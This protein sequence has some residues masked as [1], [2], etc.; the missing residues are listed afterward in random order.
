MRACPVSA[1]DKGEGRRWGGA[2]LDRRSVWALV[3]GDGAAL[4]EEKEEGAVELRRE[5]PAREDDDAEDPKR[6]LRLAS[7]SLL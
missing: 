7:A 3:D 5:A 6:A 2:P 4:V 1:L